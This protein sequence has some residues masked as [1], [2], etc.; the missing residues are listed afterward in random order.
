MEEQIN[1][2]QKLSS[3]VFW[4]CLAAFLASVGS[5][6][7]GLGTGNEVLAGVGMTCTILAAGIYSA[8]EKATDI[9][10]IK[11]SSDTKQTIM[12]QNVT[13]SSDD[14][15][16]VASVLAPAPTAEQAPQEDAVM[17]DE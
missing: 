11:A 4:V 8:A 3:R 9:A 14:M 17:G 5:S 12:Q 6:I 16:T 15:Y 1:W 13:A 2:K 10:R 7:A